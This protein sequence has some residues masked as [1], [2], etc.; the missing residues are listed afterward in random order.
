ME[1]AKPIP[2]SFVTRLMDEAK[3]VG[4]STDEYCR[5]LLNNESFYKQN[6]TTFETGS[7]P[8]KQLKGKQL[9]PSILSE[10]I[11]AHPFTENALAGHI[12]RLLPLKVGCRILWSM[13]DDSG[14]GPTPR[15]FRST[16]ASKAHAFRIFLKGTDENQARPRGDRLHSSFPTSSDAAVNRFLNQY[17]LRRT[18]TGNKY[19]TGALHDFGL[20]AISDSGTVQFTETGRKFTLLLNPVIDEGNFRGASFS[21]DE[22][23]LILS[24][25]R[26]EMNRE[27]K[28]MRHILDGIHLGS[29]TPTSLLSRIS[30]RY[31]PGTKAD[32]SNSVMPHMRSGVLGR[33]QALGLIKRTFTENR[34][35]YRVTPL[36]LVIL[37]EDMA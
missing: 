13:I 11:D 32:W 33:M 21:A 3:Q 24:Q 6:T 14:I 4:L 16:I 27:W 34:V 29:N 2:S 26:S 22:Q 19:P 7:N 5:L 30:R 31:G 8:F 17:M 15:Q 12:N 18:G 9:N 10:T 37:E 25:V 20:I 36:A 35:E 23:V 28:F 1:T